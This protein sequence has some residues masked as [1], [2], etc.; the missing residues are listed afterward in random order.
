[1][2]KKPIIITMCLLATF[3]TNSTVSS[4]YESPLY[5]L[6]SIEQPVGETEDNGLFYPDST[7]IPISHSEVIE[8]DKYEPNNSIEEAYPY[9]STTVLTSNAFVNG[10]RNCGCHVEGDKDFFWITMVEGYSYDVVLK[11]LYGHDRHIYIYEELRDGTM[12]KTQKS[13]PVPGQ[14]EHYI[15]KPKSTGRHYIEI[16]GGEPDAYYFFFAVEKVGK[17]NTALWPGEV[18]DYGRAKSYGYCEN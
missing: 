9:N 8:P 14:P 1:M 18:L 11:N 3:I 16:S 6:S 2:K 10:Y 12:T 17:I 15:Y 13:N 7:T 5:T 4:A